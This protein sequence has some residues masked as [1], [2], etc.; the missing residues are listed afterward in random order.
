MNVEN[1]SKT[2][3]NEFQTEYW[4]DTDPVAEAGVGGA[5]AVTKE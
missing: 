3:L 1:L 2:Y 4:F 5:G